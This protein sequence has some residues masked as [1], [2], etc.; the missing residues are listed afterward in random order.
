MAKAINSTIELNHLKFYVKHG[1]YSFEKEVRQFFMVD[2][3]LNVE[4]PIDQKIELQ[5]TVDYTEVYHLVKNIMETPED[6]LENLA[7]KILRAILSQYYIVSSCTCRIEK[8]SQLGG[9]GSVAICIGLEKEQFL[10]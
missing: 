7:L 4:L 5:N 6:L 10:E 8:F 2:L 3:K 1:I 9:Q